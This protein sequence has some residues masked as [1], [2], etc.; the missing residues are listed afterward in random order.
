MVAVVFCGVRRVSCGAEGAGV[1]PGPLTFRPVWVAAG[2]G[3]GGSVGEGEFGEV[4]V[5]GGV[6]GPGDGPGSGFVGCRVGGRDG[7]AGLDLLDGT[8]GAVG[9]QYRRSGGEAVRRVGQTGDGPACSTA[10]FEGFDPLVD[11]G[12][13]LEFAPR[14]D[15]DY[16]QCAGYG[17]R[18]V[19]A[20]LN[21]GK[22]GDLPGGLC[23]GLGSFAS[24]RAL[25][26]APSSQ[27]TVLSPG[28]IEVSKGRRSMQNTSGASSCALR[29]S[30]AVYRFS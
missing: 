23:V 5:V 16:G 3:E 13:E 28:N 4:A 19:N 8:A 27:I 26:M 9:H 22:T 18:V 21:V 7:I 1:F 20:G 10:L 29:A 17:S 15:T 25:S 30:S 11:H 24:S 12:D 14:G 2:G 6:D